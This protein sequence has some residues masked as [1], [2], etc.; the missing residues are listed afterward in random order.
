VSERI[1][2][3]GAAIRAL[4]VKDGWRQKDLAERVGLTQSALSQIESESQPASELTLNKIARSLQVPLDAIS[5]HPADE[6]DAVA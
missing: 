4:R 5:R 3:N 6:P 2:Q 1:P